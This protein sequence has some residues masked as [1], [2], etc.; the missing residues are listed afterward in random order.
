MIKIPPAIARTSPHAFVLR[1][2]ITGRRQGGCLRSELRKNPDVATTPSLSPHRGED[3]PTTAL[4]CKRMRDDD[5]EVP[6]SP[7]H[8][9]DHFSLQ[10]LALVHETF[11]KT[12]TYATSGTC[13]RTQT[14]QDGKYSPN[15]SR[16]SAPSHPSQCFRTHPRRGE[17]TY[18]CDYCSLPAHRS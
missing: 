2:C 1:S 15:R 11:I 8:R 6:V 7:C 3:G 10:R 14:I 4:I 9:G 17:A 12:A 18:I 16:E 5:L 13:R